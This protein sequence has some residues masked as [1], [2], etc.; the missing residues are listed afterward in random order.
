MKQDSL[1]FDDSSYV[2]NLQ[3]Q[4]FEKSNSHAPGY[5]SNTAARHI[6]GR[7]QGHYL[8]QPAVL[9]QMHKQYSQTSD[10]D[11]ERKT[12][13]YRAIAA[14]QRINRM[15]HPEQ[16]SEEGGPG[17]E[18]SEMY[19]C[20]DMIFPVE[21][22][23]EV[24]SNFHFAN[25]NSCGSI[26]DGESVGEEDSG[27]QSRALRECFDFNSSAIVEENAEEEFDARE[28]S[29]NPL[30]DEPSFERHIHDSFEKEN[31]SF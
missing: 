19:Q 13:K 12:R 11:F 3:L 23:S 9:P 8:E 26:V 1:E 6:I 31:A 7:D 15:M 29:S 18:D 2:Q 17:D 25:I 14:V 16:Q 27:S 24:A 22:S 30:E 4:K 20:Q 21:E 28:P 10:N 5:T